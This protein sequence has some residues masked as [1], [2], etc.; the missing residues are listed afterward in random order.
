[1]KVLVTG[2]A[3]F[4]GYHISKRL[5]MLGHEVVGIDNYVGGDALNTD[6]LKRH[7][8]SEFS[9]VR[10]NLTSEHAVKYLFAHHKFDVIFH[11]ACYPHEGL[12]VA[13]P[14][15][16]TKSVTNATTLLLSSAVNGRVKRF[17]NFSSMARYGSQPRYP[18]NEWMSPN[19][20][21]PYG[22]AKYAAELQVKSICDAY[23]VKWVNLIPHNIYGPFQK[24]DDP[25]RNVAAIMVNRVLQGKQPIIYGD[26]SQRRCFSFVMDLLPAI[27][28]CGLTGVAD[29]LTLNIG[30]EEPFITIKDLAYTICGIAG[31]EFKPA[32]VPARPCEVTHANCSSELARSVLGVKFD[33]P[34]KDGLTILYNWIRT[35][36]PKPFKFHLPLEIDHEKVPATWRERGMEK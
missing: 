31:V 21:D 6:D 12:S 36:G 4:L 14:Y 29:G 10:G 20:V 18:F 3:G 1:M 23:G 28:D 27:V 13:S 7:H 33:T 32:F 35:R 16:I 8:Q 2:S 22:A 26:G 5:L 11:T 25:Y 24:Y 30:P 19:P 34:L 15:L 9:F 17:V